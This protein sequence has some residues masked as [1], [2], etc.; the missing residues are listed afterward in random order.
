MTDQATY[1]STT[2]KRNYDASKG[3]MTDDKPSGYGKSSKNVD[4]FDTKMD[5]AGGTPNPGDPSYITVT[6]ETDGT[7]SI[8]WAGGNDLTTAA[9]RRQE[10]IDNMHAIANALAKA[11]EDGTLTF[12]KNYVQVAVFKDGTMA[13]Y[14]DGKGNS[15]A[16]V[17]KI[18]DALANSQ[19]STENTPLYSTDAKW[20]NGYV[21]HFNANGS[22][23]YK[24][25]SASENNN[26]E[27]I[28]NWWNK[29]NIT[30][31]DLNS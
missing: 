16:D 14:M 3:V 5:G 2:Y 24:A 20:A 1:S 18:K 22:V 29:G 25:I 26:K 21:V 19:L 17:Q 13:Y 11:Q 15:D 30:D 8:D 9:G 12:A 7:I 28:W 6:I 31:E 4:D 27:I 23:S 10:D